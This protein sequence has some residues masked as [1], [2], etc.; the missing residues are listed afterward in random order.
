MRPVTL[1]V[2]CLLIATV[3]A[4]TAC[5]AARRTRSDLDPPNTFTA[6][7]VQHV[8]PSLN[9]LAYLATGSLGNDQ[10]GEHPI[11]KGVLRSS[12]D[13][14]VTFDIVHP[15]DTRPLAELFSDDA[16]LSAPNARFASVPLIAFGRP[17][18]RSVVAGSSLGAVTGH[19][20]DPG[21]VTAV[22]MYVDRD[23]TVTDHIE[24]GGDAIGFRV[25]LEE[26]WNLVLIHTA[27]S[28]SGAVYKYLAVGEPDEVN[29]YSVPAFVTFY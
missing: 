26:G 7:R 9:V 12:G 29:W 27:E 25:S 4:I 16:S 11:G 5:D 20:T 3:A 18:E 15:A 23:V 17:V 14:T 8:G 1:R 19:G 22:F 21:D 24:V 2:T 13:L 10:V 28:P 6:A